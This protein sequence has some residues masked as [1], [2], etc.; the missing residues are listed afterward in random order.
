MSLSRCFTGCL[1]PL[2]ASGCPQAYSYRALFPFSTYTLWLT[3]PCTAFDDQSAIH[4]NQTC[5]GV[6]NADYTVTFC[7]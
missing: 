4:S 6:Q 2:E 7:P 1:I 5:P 3:N